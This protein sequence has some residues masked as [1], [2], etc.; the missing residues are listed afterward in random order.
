M[1]VCLN[2]SEPHEVSEKTEQQLRCQFPQ[3][4]FLLQ[5]AALGRWQA[6]RLIGRQHTTDLYLATS[7][8]PGEQMLVKVIREYS[9]GLLGLLEPLLTLRHPHI[10]HILQMGQVDQAQ[11]IYLLGRY[12]AA[13]SLA[14]LLRANTRLPL[15]T[16]G[17]LV[18]QIALALQYAHEH[19][20]IHGSLK[21]ENCLIVNSN[22]IQVSDFY[23][24]LQPDGMR[25][26]FVS[27]YLAPEQL[28]GTLLPASDQ[29]SLAVLAFHFLCFHLPNDE[30]K[31]ELLSP[32]DERFMSLVMR[33]PAAIGRPLAVALNQNP[34][35]RYPGVMI[36][37]RELQQALSVA[38]QTRLQIPSSTQ[39]SPSPASLRN[40][41]EH[42]LYPRQMPAQERRTSIQKKQESLLAPV[43]LAA[44]SRLPGHTE[45]V[46][47]VCWA[48]DGQH[49]ASASLDRSVLIWKVQQRIG[50]PLATL[51]GYQGEISALS[52]SPDGALLA[53]AGKDAALRIWRFV[54]APTFTARVDASWWGHDGPIT[55]LEWSPNGV[56][57]ASGGR[58]QMIRLWDPKGTQ[59]AFWQTHKRGVTAL[60]WSPDG[61]ILATGGSD[62]QIHLWNAAT[63]ALLGSYTKHS[64]EIRQVHWS[65][66]GKLLASS[67]GKKE[68]EIHIWEPRTG[69]RLAQL[70]E[71]GREIV[72]MFWARDASWLAVAA[73]DGMLRCWQVVGNQVT[74]LPPL[75]LGVMPTSI[76][77]SLEQRIAAIGT[78][79]M[80]ISL[81]QWNA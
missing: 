60:A 42:L 70:R 7:T 47:L 74:P 76:D 41:G 13:G 78:A 79:E 62:R 64:D 1:Y 34:M 26:L 20:L 2:P 51:T 48:P 9:P 71:S 12:E 17:A 40:S 30:M 72:G 38:S 19:H 50:T 31:S 28:Q 45:A 10:H 29:Y 3:C 52:W 15:E 63:K 36:F 25:Q 46:T 55:V 59:L 32:S 18:S 69:Q 4:G 39:L 14:R 54:H 6:Q 44:L 22:H 37:A 49:L 43:R 56:Q 27:P 73:R 33:F 67:S 68:A 65:P 16:I 58:D 77:G 57:L 5:G 66:D 11:A 24:G 53:T 81:Q 23:R 8:I 61:Q 35:S 21:P 80:I 75:E